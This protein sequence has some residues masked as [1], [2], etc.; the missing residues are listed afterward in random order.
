M[1]T[2]E[3]IVKD[4]KTLPP[5]KLGQAA[6]YIHHLKTVTAAERR[7]ALDRAYGCLTEQEAKEMEEAITTNCER[8]DAS[9]W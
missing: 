6:D 7:A 9:E 1:S 2:L 4:L 8:I 5:A 3:L